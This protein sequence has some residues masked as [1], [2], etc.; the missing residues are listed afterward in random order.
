[1]PPAHTSY[2][3]EHSSLSLQAIVLLSGHNIHACYQCRRCAAGC[4]VAEEC[5]EAPDQ[6]IRKLLFSDIKAA[7]RSSLVKQC[8]ACH[9][10]GTRCPNGIQTSR[11]IEILKQVSHKTE[12]AACRSTDFHDA[13]L[14]VIRRHGR[15]HEMLGMV[16]YEVK[17]G[18][19]DIVRGNVKLLFKEMLNQMRLGIMMMKKKRMHLDATSSK[20]PELSAF[21]EKYEGSRNVK[22]GK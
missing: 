11:I 6:I 21:F 9:T 5:G 19:R 15:F 22:S 10:C 18:I 16:L 13:F 20:A 14:A 3:I 2:S 7:L 1:M 12:E 8:I 4:P 17:A